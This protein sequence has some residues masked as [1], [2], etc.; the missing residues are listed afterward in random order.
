M[1][2][3]VHSSLVGGIL[4]AAV[5]A[6]LPDGAAAEPLTAGRNGEPAQDPFLSRISRVSPTAAFQ[7]SFEPY[8][9]Q[10]TINM[11]DVRLPG[12]G[13]LD[14]VVQRYYKSSIWNR[15]DDPSGFDLIY[16]AA[17]MDTGDALGGNGWQLHMGK[18]RNPAGLGSPG[19]QNGCLSP[20]NPVVVMPD[21]S[22]HVLYQH[23]TLFTE[24]DGWVRITRNRWL[25]RYDA[26]QRT[27]FLTLTDGTVYEF[28]NPFDLVI[29]GCFAGP[30]HADPNAHEQLNEYFDM[31]GNDYVQ[32]TA[33]EDVNGN[34][35]TI[36]YDDTHGNIDRIID[37]YGRTVE[38]SY[39][40]GDSDSS[41]CSAWVR[42]PK[43]K[44][45]RVTNGF[46]SVLQRWSY[47]YESSSFTE[48]YELPTLGACVP[49]INVERRIQRLRSVTPPEG[50]SWFFEYG[51]SSTSERNGK[52]MLSRVTSP[53]RGTITYDYS[54]KSYDVGYEN[55]TV[56]YAVLSAKTVSGRGVPSGTW[57]YQYPS[58]AGRQGHTTTISGPEGFTERYTFHGWGPFVHEDS[59]LWKVG[60][61]DRRS[62]SVGGETVTVENDFEEGDL[63]SNDFQCSRAWN[64][65][66]GPNQ[67]RIQQGVSFVEPTEQ[68][69]TVARGTD[70]WQTISSS[71]DRY[72]NPTL[73][74]ENGEVSRTTTI[75]YWYDTSLNLLN[76]RVASRDPSPG[77]SESFV[78]DSLGRPIEQVVN[79]IETRF[80]YDSSGRLTKEVQENGTQDFETRF[81]SYAW[82]LP[83]RIETEL[84]SN[85]IR[86]DR[87][88]SPL[89]LITSEEDGRGASS[90]IE[91]DY[92]ALGRL[93][94]ITPP[95]GHSTF[96][97]YEPDHSS[98]EVE[99]AS[100]QFADGYDLEY[101]FD[102]FDRLTERQDH[103]TG[104]RRVLTYD[105]LGRREEEKLYPGG[106]LADTRRFDLLG[107]TTEVEHADGS[108]VTWGYDGSEVTITDED[109]RSTVFTYEAFGDPESRRLASVRDARG[110]TWSYDYDPVKNELTSVDAP[111]A[112]GDRSFTYTSQHFLATETHPESGTTS[113]TYTPLGWLESRTRGGETVRYLYDRA[114]RLT[115]LD[116]PG[117]GDDVTF[118]YN[119]AG[120]RT[121]MASPHGT[122]RYSYDDNQRVT[123]KRSIVGG[124][125]YE[126]D[127]AYDAR[128]RLTQITYPSGRRVQY[129]YDHADRVTAVEDPGGGGDFV[130]DVTYHSS[131]AIGALD[132]EGSVTTQ[133]GYDSRNRL[134]SLHSSSPSGGDL[135]DLSFDYDTV[136]NLSDWADHR[137]PTATRSFGYDALNRLTSADAAGLW[138]TRSYTYDAL[139]NRT[140]LTAG[141][142]TITYGYDANGRLTSVTGGEAAGSYTYDTAGRLVSGPFLALPPV[143]PPSVPVLEATKS[144]SL[145][146]DADGNGVASPG[147]VLRYTVTITNAGTAPATGVVFTDTLDPNTFLA[148]SVTTTLGTVVSEEPEIR[149]D[150]GT[151]T[152]GASATIT[153]DVHIRDPF[154]LGVNHLSNQGSVASTELESE[155]TDDP[156]TPTDD[157]ATS[158]SVSVPPPPTPQIEVDL[159]SFGT[160]QDL[161]AGGLA[162]FG[163]ATAATGIDSVSLSFADGALD[164]V[165]SFQYG[166]PRPEICDWTEANFGFRDPNCP[167]VG[168][169]ALLDSR[170]LWNANSTGVFDVVASATSIGG[171]SAE[172][173]RELRFH[174]ESDFQSPLVTIEHPDPALPEVQNVPTRLRGWALDGTGIV[175][176]GVSVDGVPLA[177]SQYAYGVTRA[178]VCD[179]HSAVGDPNC[180]TAS[181]EHVGWEVQLDGGQYALG[182]LHTLSVTAADA[183]GRSTTEEV[184]FEIVDKD[185]DNTAQPFGGQPLQIPDHPM[186]FQNYDVGG[187]GVAYSDNTPGNSASWGCDY[188]EIED[189]DLET[190]PVDAAPTPS[191]PAQ[192]SSFICIVDFFFPGDCRGTVQD[193]EAGEWLGFTAE[194][195]EAGYYTMYVWVGSIEPGGAFHLEI[196]G[197][198]VTGVTTTPDPI[199]INAKT[200][201][202]EDV[203]LE[204]PPG[205]GTRQLRLVFDQAWPA[206]LSFFFFERQADPPSQPFGGSPRTVAVGAKLQ[207]EHYDTSPIYIGQSI[208][209]KD[210]SLGNQAT[211][212]FRPHEWVDAGAEGSRTVVQDLGVGEWLDYTVDVPQ[213]ETFDLGIRFSNPSAAEGDLDLLVDGQLQ[214]SVGVPSTG[215]GWKTGI[216]EDFTLP[217]GQHKLR[218]VPGDVSYKLDYMQFDEPSPC[219][220]TANDDGPFTV[221]YGG[222]W[223]SAFFNSVLQNDS[224]SD[225]VSLPEIVREP[226]GTLRVNVSGLTYTPP[227]EYQPTDSF[228]YTVFSNGNPECWDAATVYL[229]LEPPP[230]PSA[231]FTRTCE[232]LLC[233][234]DAGAS[235]GHGLSYEWSF[236]DG[237]AGVGETT[238]HAFDAA[239]SYTVTL[240]VIDFQDRVAT[241]GRMVQPV[242][243]VDDSTSVVF[244]DSVTGEL[245]DLLAN[246]Q[247][248]QLLFGGIVSQPSDGTLT[249][250]GGTSFRYTPTSCAAEDAF[251]YQVGSNTATYSSDTATVRVEVFPDQAPSAAFDVA[252]DL[253]SCQLTDRS[254]DDS[255]YQIVSWDFGD[256][257]S[258]ASP[259]PSHTYAEPG[260][261]TITLRVSDLCGQVAT[262][263]QSVLVGAP[264]SAAF[265]FECDDLGCAFDASDST[266]DNG[267]ATYTW[268][269]GDG[270]VG[271]GLLAAHTYATSGIYTVTLTVVDVIGLTDAITQ[272]V[273]LPPQADFSVACDPE[274]RSCHF[275]GSAS[276]P[277][278][279]HEWDFGDGS[280]AAAG[281]VQEH[282]YA[283]SGV[284]T[285]TLT[286]TDSSGQ[287]DSASRPVV[288]PPG[289]AFTVSCDSLDCTFDASASSPGVASYAWS[290]GHDGATGTGVAPTHEFPDAGDYEVTLTVT[291]T[292]GQSAT[293]TR[294]VSV[295]DEEAFLLILLDR[296]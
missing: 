89:G 244:G 178:D 32:A 77:G 206:A 267:I 264:P 158:T 17:G 214:A 102:G 276:T 247:G 13:G 210:N 138:G 38:F 143:E 237:T 139:G 152:A 258:T 136:G 227:E 71:F 293:T 60:L 270:N 180:A 92:D 106:V 55:G 50:N 168:F 288:I 259:N 14:L 199:C 63:L 249:L 167:N 52:L 43:L 142:S 117:S 5:L 150:L 129:E 65:L 111:L 284:F 147:D 132:F 262:A 185:S 21:G 94:R 263:S 121:E 243:G 67:L 149:V 226:A 3:V 108:R 163:F 1:R 257:A 235:V 12:K 6:A 165:E 141:G 91:Y 220:A 174:F 203:Y 119:A 70:S 51:S 97:R 49:Q 248:P 271:T 239:T 75:D 188:R 159:Q 93:V 113:Y 80:T 251:V 198:P 120:L 273:A 182:S 116:P 176:F 157:D 186:L 277:G 292:S 187:Q 189:V 234:F 24:A 213:G 222:S 252:C 154:P 48:T 110:N 58:V 28:R 245:A 56:E 200:I 295:F 95:L 238:T 175:S 205:G 68:V 194:I 8:S 81:S 261:Y 275:D 137:D 47:A 18:I 46:G 88:I 217:P 170:S 250:P 221:P 2:R 9:G 253:L 35:I 39:D 98:V 85:D 256:G 265:T 74:T 268:S 287:T 289:A 193:I 79:G 242:R 280:P 278:V 118:E 266:D 73:I 40:S 64:G 100:S 177:P 172:D 130:T 66:L 82:G 166:W 122:F 144:D 160:D 212:P 290:F 131:G 54:A 201:V 105:A 260:S 76:G 123:H 156:G 15:T 114:G 112:T 22:E 36:E 125:T 291:D 37:T 294:M 229:D 211:S 204:P 33:I 140:G 272:P 197:V 169:W 164:G 296:R 57:S 30:C 53:S 4:V 44:E 179:D 145:D 269:F 124:N 274:A 96:I 230:P 283:T 190:H 240:T 196:D 109:G 99:R 218:L 31:V 62:T 286:V 162:V 223:S 11:V 241:K 133:H 107:R 181:R 282:T 195:A 155:P 84:G 61:L 148:R 90:E 171:E 233:T 207:T 255:G 192:E 86:I 281:P 279:S 153:F 72:G 215:G 224:P 232:G 26:N 34:R 191:S 209:Y 16:H 78:F 161:E 45:L 151:L 128:D 59:N 20:D 254:S 42:R 285:V 19:G 10:L 219:P 41:A 246:D 173:R 126:I 216:L 135:V 103:E 184:T 87:E 83:A 104:D 236:G 146:F 29:P 183:R 228:D 7:E 115:K 69:V 101:S 25:F 225:A 23:P 27:F 231:D 134:T 208:G 127:Y 202:I